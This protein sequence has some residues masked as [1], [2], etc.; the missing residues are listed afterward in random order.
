MCVKLHTIPFKPPLGPPSDPTGRRG[1]IP[2]TALFHNSHHVWFFFPLQCWV[3]P[4]WTVENPAEDTQLHI[5]STR[6]H[7][8]LGRVQRP[9]KP[10]AF[11]LFYKCPIGVKKHDYA[12][13][14]LLCYLESLYSLINLHSV[15]YEV[16]R[17]VFLL[18]L[19]LHDSLQLDL[20]TKWILQLSW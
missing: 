5:I 14:W 9:V 13:S 11:Y 17:W 7:W 3:F 6:L 2:D 8:Q 1:N 4:A 12:W 16:C 10:V 18:I 15:L 19:L 20:L